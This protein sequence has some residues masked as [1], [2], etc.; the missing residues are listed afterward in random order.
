MQFYRSFFIL[1]INNLRIWEVLGHFM[2]GHDE[3]TAHDDDD[4]SQ[5]KPDEQHDQPNKGPIGDANVGNL[6]NIITIPCG[7]H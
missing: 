5:M 4:G 2:A 3:F 7:E 1:H 6:Q